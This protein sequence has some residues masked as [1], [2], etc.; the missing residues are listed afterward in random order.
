MPATSNILL[1]FAQGVPPIQCDSV[2]S[3]DAALD[4]LHAAEL[5]R[6]ATDADYCPLQVSIEFDKYAVNTGPGPPKPL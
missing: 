6:M 2:A 4:R 1:H 5:D 3:L